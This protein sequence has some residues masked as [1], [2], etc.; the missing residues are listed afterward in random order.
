M[1]LRFLDSFMSLGL[2]P[3]IDKL[4]RITPYTN[5]IIDN[6]YHSINLDLPINDIADHLPDFIMCPYHF[7]IHEIR[8]SINVRKCN[9]ESI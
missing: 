8:K 4:T 1:I 9:D 3:C 7:Q 5:T 6:I 2:I